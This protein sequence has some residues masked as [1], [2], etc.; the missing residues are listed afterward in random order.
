MKR[1][2]VFLAYILLPIA[3]FAQNA[4][5]QQYASRTDVKYVSI[6]HTTLAAMSSQKAVRVGDLDLSDLI[7]HI[8]NILIISAKEPSAMAAVLNDL[9][10][11]QQDNSYET[12]LTKNIHGERSVSLFRIG[13]ERNEFVLFSLAETYT[14]VVITGSF[15]P[16]QFQSFFL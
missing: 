10:A 16:N 11:L 13:N 5:F 3:M 4:I 6:S 9:K 15:T 12:L 7:D 14:I 8:D 2:P 1:L